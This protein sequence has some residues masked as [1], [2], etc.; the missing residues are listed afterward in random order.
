MKKVSTLF[1]AFIF[2]SL[3][4][5]AFCQSYSITLV[6]KEMVGTDEQWTWSV[7][8]PNPGNGTNGTLQDVSH[9]SIDLPPSAEAALVSAEYSTDNVNWHSVAIKIDR[10]PSLKCAYM[11]VLKFD[12][13]TTGTQ[14]IYYRAKFNQVF[15]TNPSAYAFIKTGAGAKVCNWLFFSGPKEPYVSGSY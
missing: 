10:D 12:I 11:D 2:A 7:S 5:T 6:S 9:W 14:P 4:S 15:E 8:N 1:G 13:G 3:F